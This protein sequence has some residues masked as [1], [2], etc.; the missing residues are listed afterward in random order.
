MSQVTSKNNQI[1][2]MKRF[3]GDEKYRIQAAT[4]NLYNDN[5]KMNLCLLIESDEA[6]AQSEDTASYFQMLNW[7]LNLVEK[8]LEDSQLQSGF[9]ANIPEAYDEDGDGWITNFYF[10]EH[11]GSENNKIEIIERQGDQ[12]LIRVSGEIPDVNFY[13]GSKPH[14]TLLVETWFTKDENTRRSMN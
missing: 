5:E 1:L 2:L 13:D 3:N 11:Q 12:L 10:V 9:T 8:S 6:I 4:W 7:E 14:A